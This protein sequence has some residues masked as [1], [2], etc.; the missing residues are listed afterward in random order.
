[1]GLSLVNSLLFFVPPI[2]WNLAFQQIPNE[3]FSGSA[4]LWVV[5]A[6][7]V[8]RSSIM[9]YSAV[10]PIN[11]QHDQFLPGLAVYAAGLLSAAPASSAFRAIS[12]R[13]GKGFSSGSP[14]R[15]ACRSRLVWTRL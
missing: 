15:S 4:P 12:C 2:A 14:S 1:M 6:E 8:F 10:L 5:I 3:Y 7:N 9:A 11:T 13:A